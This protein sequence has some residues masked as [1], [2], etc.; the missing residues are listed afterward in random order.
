MWI[1]SGRTAE[2]AKVV[3]VDA[4]E[5]FLR[6][7]RRAVSKQSFADQVKAQSDVCEMALSMEEND[8][9]PLLQGAARNLNNTIAI[10]ALIRVK[11]AVE[12]P[13][14][15]QKQEPQPPKQLGFYAG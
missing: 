5:K 15:P 2:T 3:Y 14:G 13:V 12:E 9:A 8:T 1:S 4:L 11:H 6:W 7:H 10:G